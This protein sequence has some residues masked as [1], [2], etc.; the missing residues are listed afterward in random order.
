MIPVVIEAAKAFVAK[1]LGLQAEV[2]AVDKDDDGWLATAE[3][4]LVDQYMRK[5]ARRDLIATFELR[6]NEECEVQSYARKA[7]RERG[8]LVT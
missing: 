7:M 5:F 6:L 3:A 2:I 1:E 4:I 8:S